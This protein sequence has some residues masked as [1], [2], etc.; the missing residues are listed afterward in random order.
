MQ[1][2]YEGWSLDGAGSKVPWLGGKVGARQGFSGLGYG[3][4]RRVPRTMDGSRWYYIFGVGRLSVTRSDTNQRYLLEVSQEP[5]H[6]IAL[7]RVGRE[8]EKVPCLG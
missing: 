5:T 6:Q 3:L 1:G 7:A 8:Y 4:V 2:A